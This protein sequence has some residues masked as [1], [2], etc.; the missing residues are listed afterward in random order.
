MSQSGMAVDVH[1]HGVIV[2]HHESEWVEAVAPWLSDGI[3]SG[4]RAVVITT[5]ERDALLRAAMTG[6]GVDLAAAEGSGQFLVLDVQAAVSAF[7]DDGMLDAEAFQAIVRDI[8][9]DPGT[10]GN[11]A[12]PAPS[13]I[14]MVGD[15]AALM[16][17]TGGERV[18]VDIERLCVEMTAG[19]PV[20]LQCVYAADVLRG[21]DLGLVRQVFDLHT[22]VSVTPDRE[23]AGSPH[24]DAGPETDLDRRVEIFDGVPQSVARVRRF[25]ADALVRRYPRDIVF[26]CSLI[27]SE[28]ATNAYLHT[29][30]S[31]FR[32]GMRLGPGRV[33]ITVEDTSTTP[34]SMP[35]PLD[36]DERGRGVAIIDALSDR[37]GADSLPSGKVVWAEVLTA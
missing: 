34:P 28:M 35:H 18:A 15:A 29:G 1:G 7:V 12:A 30:G 14:R 4:L 8:L 16:V 33:R 5:P 27:A 36:H 11:P 19:Q 25:V 37:W 3:R 31:P 10:P 2:F 20:S 17:S 6:G 21:V 26:D 32:V 9:E 22:Q 13:G 24:L 23:T